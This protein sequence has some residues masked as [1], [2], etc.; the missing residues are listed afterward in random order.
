MPIYHPTPPNHTTSPLASLEDL[1]SGDLL[2]RCTS[3]LDKIV[4]FLSEQV[5][6]IG[7][8][9]AMVLVPLP[10]MLAIDWR[11]TLVS[12]ILVV[13]ISAFSYVFFRKMRSRFL[14]KDEAEG[15]LTATV[16]ENL[17]GIRVVRSFARQDFES[18]RFEERNREH[19]DL[20]NRL[21]VLM[22]RFW[23]ISDL[24]CFGQ[25]LL[26]LCF[27]LWWLSKG[28]LEV[29]AFYFF[30][31]AVMMFL[32]PVRMLGRILAELGKALVAMG[33]INEILER[34][35]EEDDP[36]PNVSMEVSKP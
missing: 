25:Q 30:L 26:V 7:R 27:G 10:L 22:A 32:W 23:S 3:D 29:G 21:Y 13:P 28:T 1:E 11:M 24:L 15:R 14:V 2:Q 12:L 6:M 33:R 4:L 8:A 36:S 35:L 17:A 34:P 19:R 5:V 9:V 16:N 18:S 20:D 31:S